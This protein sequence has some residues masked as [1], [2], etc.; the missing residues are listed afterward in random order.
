[1]FGTV[2]MRTLM[3]QAVAAA[4]VAG[5]VLPAGA[6]EPP[7]INPFGK[8]PPQRE[9]A[10]ETPVPASRVLEDAAIPS[11]QDIAAAV[12]NVLQVT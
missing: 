6:G 10:A 8:A 3:V 11:A 2:N 5:V 7:V 12:V 4:A 9:A 1:M